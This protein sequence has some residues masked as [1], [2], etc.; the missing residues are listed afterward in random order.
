MTAKLLMRRH[1]SG[2]TRVSLNRKF[3]VY[4]ICFL[5]YHHIN[6]FFYFYGHWFTKKL[7]KHCN[8]EWEYKPAILAIFVKLLTSMGY[9]SCHYCTCKWSL[10]ME[11]SVYPVLLP[12]CQHI[13]CYR[14]VA[15]LVLLCLTVSKKIDKMALS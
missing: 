11:N 10:D 12:L 5:Q 9:F 1:Y 3:H 4:P 14:I 2:I 15:S 13:Q 6:A 7:T 8:L